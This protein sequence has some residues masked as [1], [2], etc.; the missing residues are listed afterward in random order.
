MEHMASPV[1]REELKQE[2]QTLQGALIEQMRDMQVRNNEALIEQMRDMQ[3]EIIR[4]FMT[5]QESNAHRFDRVEKSD[6]SLAERLAAME[7]RMAEIEKKLFKV[8]PAA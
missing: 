1:T 6:S 8:P 7:R 4:V 5:F 3:S 2:L